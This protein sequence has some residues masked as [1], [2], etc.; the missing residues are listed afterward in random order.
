[1]SIISTGFWLRYRR[2]AIK[3]YE[4]I[5]ASILVGGAVAVYFR[6]PASGVVSFLAGVLIDLDHMLDY[7]F[8]KGIKLDVREFYDYCLNTKYKRLS[9]VMHSYELI[10][11]FWLAI[12]FFSLGVMWKAAAIGFTQHLALDLIRNF[13][14]GV[15]DLKGYSFL[16]RMLHRFDSDKY[17]RR[18]GC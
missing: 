9:L 12:A 5:T 8:A 14:C 6:S 4:H 16:Y 17:I 10:V 2:R 11:L 13:S 1:L 3:P 15:M 7:F 18:R